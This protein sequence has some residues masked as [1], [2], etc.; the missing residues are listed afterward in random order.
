MDELNNRGEFL[1]AGIKNGE[2]I[3]E[4]LKFSKQSA[5]NTK[6]RFIKEGCDDVYIAIV[7]DEY[8]KERTSER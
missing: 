8:H 6:K 3:W 7:I 5:A 2:W 4:G 1:V